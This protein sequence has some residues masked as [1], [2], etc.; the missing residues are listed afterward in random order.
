LKRL[1]ITFALGVLAFVAVY[2]FAIFVSNDLRLLYTIGGVL[3]F[4]GAIWLGAKGEQQWVGVL[5]LSGPLL[6][7]FGYL[8]LPKIPALWPNLLLWVITAVIGVLFLNA[9]YARRKF[10]LCGTGLLLIVSWWYCARY[11]PE[12]LA[13]SFNRIRNADAPVFSLQPVSNGAV[14]LTPMPG[15]ILV[16]DF[17]S[18]SCAPCIAELPEL[19]AVRADLSNDRNIAFVLVASDR[20]NDTPE[21]FRS[22]AQRRHLTLPLA[23][24]VGG[25]A[26]DSFRLTGVPALVV[27]DRTGRVRL[28]REGYNS[29]E[30]NFRSYLVQFLKT[31]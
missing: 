17:F 27:I 28:T 23:F 22:F 26:H 14:P 6:F 21:R 2:S 18:T 13:R 16:I 19:T 11:V 8:I 15:K 3:L 5:L 29:S 20:G 9:R 31:L 4:C 25:K 12:Q 10:A 24:D 1:F 7:G 30:T